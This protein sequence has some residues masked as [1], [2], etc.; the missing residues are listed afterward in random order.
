MIEH[1]KAPTGWIYSATDKNDYEVGLDQSEKH[2]GTRCGY[3]KSVVE[4]PKPF[5]NLSSYFAPEEYLDKRLRMSAW[6]KTELVNSK[7]QLWLRVDGDW[8]SASSKPGCFDNMDDRPIV[9]STAWRKYDLV[10]DIPKTSTGVAFGLMLLGKGQ[11]WLDDVSFEEV[12]ED[13]PL[14]GKYASTHR[15]TSRPKNLSFED[16]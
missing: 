10:V 11:A 8:K 4:E 2:S 12:S 5:G 16:D 3:L 14:T 13:V 15:T 1:K 6:V 7:A 9:G